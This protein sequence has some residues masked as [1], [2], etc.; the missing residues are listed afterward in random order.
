MSSIWKEKTSDFESEWDRVNFQFSFILAKSSYDDDFFDKIFLTWKL[1]VLYIAM[2]RSNC[3]LKRFRTFID[4]FFFLSKNL[5]LKW[6]IIIF[7]H[8][9]CSKTFHNFKIYNFLFP[10][11]KFY[12]IL[13]EEKLIKAND[14][15]I[16]NRHVL[17]PLCPLS[18]ASVSSTQLAAAA[19]KTEI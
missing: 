11:Q 15:L 13:V 8:V 1:V 17:R 7:W 19:E 10:I 18:T 9:F 16:S 14:T 4:F 5:H 12:A 3:K 6:I 2:K